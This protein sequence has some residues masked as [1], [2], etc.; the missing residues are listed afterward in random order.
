MNLRLLRF[1]SAILFLSVLAGVIRAGP[2]D[3]QD[4]RRKK[5]LIETGW[6]MPDTRRLRENLAQMEMRPFD[7]VVFEAVGRND[8]G[9]SIKLSWAFL[10]QPWQ[11]DWFQPCID[12]LRA[13]KF[14]RF[15][16]NFVVFNANP[17]DVDWFDDEGW[18]QIVGH[19]RIA[20][21]LARQSGCKG[22]L[23]DPEPYSPPHAQFSYAAQPQHDRHTFEEYCVKARQRG[24]E[25]MQAVAAEYPDITLFCYFMDSISTTATGQADPRRVL[26]TQGYGLYP[27]FI[28]GWLDAAGA[29]VTLVDGCESAYLYNSR[30]EYLEAAAL[31]KGACQ[32]LV[33]P[34]NRAKYRAQVQVG[35]GIYL[36]AYWNPKDSQWGRWYV[37][38]LGGPRVDRLGANVQT[39]LRV[40]DEYVWVYG[41]KFRWWPTPNRSVREQSWPEALPGCEKALRFARDPIEY[42]REEI[43]QMENAKEAVNLARNADFGA[44]EVSVAGGRTEKWREGRPP[45]GWSAWQREDSQGSFTWDRTVGAAGKGSAR[46]ANVA[47]GCFVQRHDVRPGQR[48]AIRAVRRL[49]GAGYAQIRVRWQTAD[50]GW[51]AVARDKLI[52]CQG[53]PEQWSEMFGVVEVPKG[54]GKLVILLGVG[55]QRGAEDVAWYDDVGL[56]RLP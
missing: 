5:K 46:A 26:A 52:F 55:G 53:R 33:S 36:D 54:V 37:D 12:D 28:D 4:A 48:Y 20:A 41:E 17:G 6:D 47:D 27:A 42:A 43:A 7:G 9:K 38:G 15:T 44:A 50:G 11:R 8:Q 24:R 51:T 32:E 13:C 31:I 14:T 40:A 16:D 3:A 25:V 1:L 10:N 18:Q 2:V 30:Q 23:F 56:Y 34:E 22:I 21:W 45:A 49:Q 29:S 39:A 35:F 19:W